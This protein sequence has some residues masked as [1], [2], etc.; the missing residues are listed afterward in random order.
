MR[1]LRSISA[2]AYLYAEDHDGHSPPDSH[3]IKALQT[4]LPTESVFQCP[5]SGPES[6][7]YV[8]GQA[9]AGRI[10][11]NLPEVARTVTFFD[12]KPNH[13]VAGGPADIVARHR[14][15]LEPPVAMFAF[16][17]GHSR[18]ATPEEAE[19]FRWE[20]SETSR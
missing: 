8:Y 7:G 2:A 9:A 16:A 11:R 18:A 3:W 14:R 17:D 13:D 19:A 15:W 12:G 10:W 1:N 6:G 5:A 20:A 4:Y